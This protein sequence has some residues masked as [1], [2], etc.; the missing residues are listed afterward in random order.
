MNNYINGGEITPT[1]LNA[2]AFEYMKTFVKC[3]NE[4][5][6]FYDIEEGLLFLNY[7][8]AKRLL[9]MYCNY[10]E[11]SFYK[12]HQSDLGLLP[13]M[14]ELEAIP[15]EN[16]IKDDIL[17]QAKADAENVNINNLL[18]IVEPADKQTYYVPFDVFLNGTRIV[19]LFVEL[20]LRHE[21]SEKIRFGGDEFIRIHKAYQSLLKELGITV[22]KQFIVP[23]PKKK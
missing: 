6:D 16:T 22:K 18:T 19:K 23:N 11:H 1:K 13:R 5:S 7:E 17:S 14:I 10:Q 4:L 8:D 12:K 21:H 20:V 9:S 3:F 15:S 2:Y